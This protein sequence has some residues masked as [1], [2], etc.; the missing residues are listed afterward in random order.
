MQEPRRAWTRGRIAIVV[1]AVTWTIAATTLVARLNAWSQLVLMV[2][3]PCLAIAM[4]AALVTLMR[5][6]RAEGWRAALPL[7]ACLVAWPLSDGVGGGVR[8]AWFLHDRPALEAIVARAAAQPLAN[9]APAVM[10]DLSRTSPWLAERAFA[11]RLADGTLVVEFLTGG[12]V[13]LKHAGF[14][15]TSGDAPAQALEDLERWPR[16]QRVAA[17]WFRVAD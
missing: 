5:F 13:P 15:Y 12:A 3:T 16:R 17:H 4:I 6:G 9:G 8:W 1:I 11:R 2:A 14:L 10:L 7:L